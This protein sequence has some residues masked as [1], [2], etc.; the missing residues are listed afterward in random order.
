[1]TRSR[2]LASDLFR[3]GGGGL[4][5]RPLRVILSALGI[6]IGIAAMIAVVGVSS[7]SQAKLEKQLHELGTNLLTAGPASSMMSAPVPMA[8]NAVD[9]V[10][11]IDGVESA[12][13]VA[14]LSLNAYRNQYVDPGNSNGLSVDVA[15]LR[16]L[17]VTEAPVTRGR[18]FDEASAELPT[19]VLGPAAATALGIQDAGS[20]IHV[21]TTD[22][23]VIGILGHSPL[24]PELDPAVLI[25]GPAARALLN[26][27]GNPTTIYERSSDAAVLAVQQVLSA[28]I[29]PVKPRNVAVA[30]PSDALKA[31][32]AVDDSLNGLLLGVGSVA[33]LVGGIGIANTMVISVLERRR[34]IGLRRALGATR[35]HIRAQFLV[36]AFLLSLL[37]GIGGAALGT[38]AVAIFAAANEAPLVVPIGIVAA[39][40][41]ATVVIGMVAGSYP[42]ITAARTPPAIALTT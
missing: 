42:A 7:T 23:M 37:G 4:R 8:V 27:K 17:T 36:E 35:G 30:R 25:P 12:A 2:L 13:S 34:E 6:A 10:L 11:R 29:D 9:R 3:I 21:G 33:L 28:T 16:L 15:D 31:K 22:F 26:W 14:A 38:G 39:G 19:T 32:N 20:M 24:A 41:G 1:M 5:L 40:V 18:W